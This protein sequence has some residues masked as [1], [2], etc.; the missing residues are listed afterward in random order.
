MN[1]AQSV[2]A[3]FNPGAQPV[4][5]DSVFTTDQNGLAA[6]SGNNPQVIPGNG[7][8]V[9]P[10]ITKTEFNPGDP[11][12]L[13]VEA[14]NQNSTDE[15]ASFQ[16]I[17]KNP[18][19]QDVPALEWSGNEDTAAGILDWYI[20]STIPAGSPAG[21]YTFTGKI[22]FNGVTT[23]ASTNFYVSGSYQIYL[24]LILTNTGG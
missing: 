17:V 15:T 11:I 16:W 21:K 10:A 6:V 7:L 20:S 19:G 24:P 3:T 1:T 14:N 12:W 9:K 23:S 22:T 4:S 8:T 5:V 2:T 13:F 18:A